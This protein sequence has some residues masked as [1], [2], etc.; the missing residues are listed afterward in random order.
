MNF[1]SGSFFV[2]IAIFFLIWPWARKETN[3]RW[4][5]ITN[6]IEYI[7]KERGIKWISFPD[8]D[9]ISYDGSHLETKSATRLSF[10]TAVEIKNHIK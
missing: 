8:T 6:E 4:T 1:T 2:F 5:V 9:Y 7:F 10:N 3:R